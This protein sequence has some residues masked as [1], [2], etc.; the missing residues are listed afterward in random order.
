M[1]TPTITRHDSPLDHPPLRF[2]HRAFY[3]ETLSLLRSVRDHDFESLQWMCDDDFG[4]VDV[5]PSGRARVI[6][7]KPEWSEWFHELFSTLDALGADTD[8]EILSY[9]AFREQTL[10]YSVVEF[11]QSLTIDG[12]TATFDCV[13]TIIWKK[14]NRGWREARWHGSVI[15]SDIPNELRELSEKAA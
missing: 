1:S 7:N 12:H 11:R 4:I 13:A 9:K 2:S 3:A 6:R 15:S 10:G 14:T 5:D 8:S